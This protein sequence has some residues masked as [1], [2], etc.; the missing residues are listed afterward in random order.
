MSMLSSMTANL[1][2]RANELRMF[3]KAMNAPY[4]LPETK[5][6]TRISMLN[7][8]VELRDAADTIDYLRNTCNDLQSENAKLQESYDNL[9]NATWDRAN[10]RAIDFMEEDE[11]RGLCADLY[12]YVDELK[13]L[14]RDMWA[15]I[16]HVE[17]TDVH[18]DCTDCPLDGTAAC[19]FE[20]R[21]IAFGIEAD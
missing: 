15:C 7:S 19:D 5:E 20:G 3:A 12:D 2:N 11:L 17:G 18:W 21:L 8:S 9:R 4:I 1:R 13:A 10:A 14:A 16:E 6:S